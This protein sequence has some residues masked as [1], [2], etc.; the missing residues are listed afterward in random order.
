MNRFNRIALSLLSSLNLIALSVHA[1]EEDRKPTESVSLEQKISFKEHLAQTE[2][3]KP[4][5]D[6][7]Q[8]KG[9]SS[10]STLHWGEY[11]QLRS[12][13]YDGKTIELEDGSIWQV[14]GSHYKE[15]LNWYS[16]DTLIIKYAPWYSLYDYEICNTT[17][18]KSIYAN[19][20][21]TSI[22]FGSS[23]LWIGMFCR[24]DKNLQIALND[25][26][27]WTIYS[28]DENIIHS[29]HENDHIIIGTNDG[30]FTKGSY[31]YILI[32]ASL[33]VSVRAACRN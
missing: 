32:N 16:T 33:N 29:W 9:A 24:E 31:P 13:A 19:L 27:L 11:H 12:V 23:S 17:T 21:T 18:H 6:E 28:S 2:G 5:A 4:D 30:Y 25:G 8:S 1:K 7:V 3:Q 10:S 22:L 26:S 20:K 15:P 14:C